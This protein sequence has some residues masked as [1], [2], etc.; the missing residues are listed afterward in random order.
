MILYGAC[1]TSDFFQKVIKQ[2]C[3]GAA[4]ASESF[5]QGTPPH[6]GGENTLGFLK[7]K[8]AEPVQGGMRVVKSQTRISQT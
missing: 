8:G 2:T 6:R 4:A 1:V 3:V 7:F 5:L